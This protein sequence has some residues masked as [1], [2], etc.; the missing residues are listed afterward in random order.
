MDR[1]QLA[2]MLEEGMSLAAI[3]RQLGRHES[4]VAYWVARHGLAAGRAEKY[5]ARGALPREELEKLIAGSLSIAQIASAVDRSKGAVRYWLNRYGL[6]T[7][8]P[9]R[10]SR[11]EASEAARRAGLGRVVMA[12]TKHGN[13]EFVVTTAGYYR[14]AR[15][16]SEAVTKRRRA[17]K[18]TLA[19]EA[20]G[21]CQLCGYDRYAGALE[22][23]HL[24]P[25]DKAFALSH[26]GVTRSLA[27]A[28]AEAAKCVL[29]CSNCH[30]EV[31]GGFVTLAAPNQARLECGAPADSSP[32]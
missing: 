10:T 30:A 14:C 13:A 9:A 11:A 20:G 1:G 3:G 18:A 29:L 12:C 15:C 31:E 7:A 4:T 23:H 25:G 26:R 21:A 19:Q 27:A 5:A 28:R 16:R 22:F 32:G 24:T 8:N 2:R 6:R 17:V